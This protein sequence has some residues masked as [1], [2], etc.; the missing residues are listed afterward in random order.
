MSRAAE[1]AAAINEAFDLA[2][3]AVN[4]LGEL[5]RSREDG[6]ALLNTIAR[7]FDAIPNPLV[8]NFAKRTLLDR[9]RRGRESKDARDFH[10]HFDRRAIEA[11]LEER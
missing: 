1:E 3:A 6:E 9:L 10:E 2:T 7:A 11:L 5:V 8:A 4:E